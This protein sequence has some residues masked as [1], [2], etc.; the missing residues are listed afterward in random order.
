MR[1]WFGVVACTP[2]FLLS[3]SD[4]EGE[5]V[6]WKTLRNAA[7]VIFGGWLASATWDF[8][9]KPII[10]F[11]GEFFLVL[12]SAAFTSTREAIYREVSIVSP[13]GLTS[14][15][16][17]VLMMALGAFIIALTVRLTYTVNRFQ[18]RRIDGGSLNRDPRESFIIK[19]IDL[20][21]RSFHLFA[22]GMAILVLF[23]IS[24]LSYIVNLHLEL[25][26]YQVI[27]A[28]YISEGERLSYAA[29]AA[30]NDGKADFVSLYSDLRSVAERNGLLKL[31]EKFL[32]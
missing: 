21:L 9:G 32:L 30:S 5:M 14:V 20:I 19:R 23:M 26:R 11:V 1:S 8:I 12:G 22:F 6:S 15:I 24:R 17:T 3:F 13:L 10:A 27:I 18:S 7:A 29:R 31:P 25:E 2:I 28:P 16:V 4:R